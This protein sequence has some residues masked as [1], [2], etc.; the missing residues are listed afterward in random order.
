MMF[1]FED[2][3]VEIIIYI[4]RIQVLQGELGPFDPNW[5]RIAGL[6]TSFFFIRQKKK[7]YVCLG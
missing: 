7:I 4:T 1:K 2:F 6:S 5:V 3:Q